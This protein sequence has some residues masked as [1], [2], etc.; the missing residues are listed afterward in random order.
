MKRTRIICTIGPATEKKEMLNLLI[1]SGMNIARLNFSHGTHANHA[2]LIKNIRSIAKKNNIPVPIIADL[3]GPKLRVGVLE[4]NILL[5]KNNEIILT[6][7]KV[8]PLKIPVAYPFLHQVVKSGDRIL[9]DDG[10][11]E[12][13]VLLVRARDIICRVVVGGKLSSHKGINV[14]NGKFK[15]SSIT[16][17]DKDD[18]SFAMQH[19]VDFVA[20]SFVRNEVDINN[21][22]K[23]INK[24]AIKFKVKKP[25]IIAKI[26][27]SEALNN[28]PKILEA[29][30]V[31][32]VARGDLGVETPAEDVPLRQKEM[33]A[34][35]RQVGKPVIIATQMLDSMIRNPRPTRAEV[36]DIANAVMDN[37]DGVMLSGETANGKYPVEAVSIMSKTILE[38][39]ASPYDDFKINFASRK[40]SELD[41]L[42][43][44][45]HVLTDKSNIKYVIDLTNNDLY[46]Y[47][48][49]W[50]SEV[51]I[52]VQSKNDISKNIF[53]GVRTFDYQSENKKSIITWLRKNKLLKGKKMILLTE[54][55]NIEI[56][57]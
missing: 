16:D 4:N 14:P 56:I 42:G 21:L 3:Q 25:K 27:N 26:E 45:I 47:V 34:M 41:A 40:I 2:T 9:L 20:I 50:R 51:D 37:V 54:D 17:K 18:L 48:S 24:N 53:W 11:L 49:K 52:L 1:K 38:V 13:K 31:V 5:K 57:G 7:G 30:D 29:T 36:S 15:N 28:F 55:N 43:Q 32:M 22:I 19:N 12:L 35:C 6:T 10:L 44:S 46:K 39:E 8:S 33:V 23:L